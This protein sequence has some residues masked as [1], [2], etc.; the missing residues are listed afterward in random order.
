MSRLRKLCV[1]I[2]HRPLSQKP[3]TQKPQTQNICKL[4][5][6]IIFLFMWDR[7]LILELRRLKQ[8][9]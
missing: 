7:I 4:K 1:F 3:Q 5:L 9:N 2:L 6:L 8:K